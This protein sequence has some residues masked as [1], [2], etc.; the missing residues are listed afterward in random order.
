ME[1][2]TMVCAEPEIEKAGYYSDQP[3]LSFGTGLHAF[4]STQPYFKYTSI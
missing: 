1:M 2:R 4:E 3:N